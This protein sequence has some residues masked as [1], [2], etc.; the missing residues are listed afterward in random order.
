MKNKNTQPKD[1][2]QGDPEP[3][4]VDIPQYQP[5]IRYGQTIAMNDP[6]KIAKDRSIV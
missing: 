6:F 1:L 4:V 3:I 5:R 2:K